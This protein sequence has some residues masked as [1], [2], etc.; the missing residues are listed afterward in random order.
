MWWR[1]LLFLFLPALCTASH[2]EEEQK[3]FEQRALETGDRI[4]QRIK[5][6]AESIDITLAGKKYTKKVNPSQLEIRYLT[7]WSEGGKFSSSPDF[8]LDLRLPN[9]EKRWQLRF[10]S[11]DEEQESHDV[12]NERISTR[13][14][15]RNYGAGLFFFEQLG[16]VKTSFLPRFQLTSPLKA[17]YTLRFEANSD[18]KPV[19]IVPKVDLYAD[20]TKGTGEF[21]QLEFR[22]DLSDKL[23]L[24]FVSTE[25]Y[26]QRDVFF[27]T[28]HVLTFDYLLN[29]AQAIGHSIAFISNNTGAFHLDTVTFGFPFT[30][31]IYPK[32]LTAGLS[33]FWT[34]VKSVH[35][36]G[37]AGISLTLDLIF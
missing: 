28:Q 4:Q 23:N 36:K 32:R 9:V 30:Q 22:S 10:S 7:S 34:F 12:T 18:T 11:Y 37:K 8:G 14:R 25:E 17:T 1:V 24:S 26:H 2:A 29:D 15:A 16:R 33:P 13:P 27:T 5:K 19:R 3:S 31:R 35:F 6:T 20:S 21:A